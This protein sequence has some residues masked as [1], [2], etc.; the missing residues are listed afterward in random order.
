MP[1]YQIANWIVNSNDKNTFQV[2][3]PYTLQQV[4]NTW[5]EKLRSEGEVITKMTFHPDKI[6]G[7]NNKI[8]ASIE[9]RSISPEGSVL[10][11]SYRRKVMIT[12]VE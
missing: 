8:F 4:A 6:P 10:L 3:T 11:F 5:A 12:L 1:K 9:S 2:T 7:F